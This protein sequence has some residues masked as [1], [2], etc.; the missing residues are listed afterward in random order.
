MQLRYPLLFLYGDDGFQVN[1]P[2]HSKKDNIPVKTDN[3]QH[4]DETNH[5][6]TVTMR[7]YY[8]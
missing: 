3:D 1:I 7:E 4:P 6:T 2:L 8:A 5:R